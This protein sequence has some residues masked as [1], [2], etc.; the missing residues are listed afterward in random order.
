MCLFVVVFKIINWPGLIYSLKIVVSLAV[1][2]I[3][4]PSK[5]FCLL[6]CCFFKIFSWSCLTYIFESEEFSIRDWYLL[7]LH[8]FSSTSSTLLTL[9]M[10]WTRI[11]PFS[12]TWNTHQRETKSVKLIKTGRKNLQLNTHVRTCTCKMH[13]VLSKFCWTRIGD[14]AQ[15]LCYVHVNKYWPICIQV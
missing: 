6:A 5:L 11:R 7:T 8:C 13:H 14:L 2:N 15:W 10:W 12:R 3:G 9:L 4:I 1:Y